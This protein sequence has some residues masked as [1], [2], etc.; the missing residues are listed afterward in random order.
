MVFLS[1]N[2]E[3]KVNPVKE[4]SVKGTNK[5]HRIL[6]VLDLRFKSYS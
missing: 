3:S 6:V 2:I 4:I 1:R 5:Y